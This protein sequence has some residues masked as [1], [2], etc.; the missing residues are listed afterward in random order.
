M[1][2]ARNRILGVSL[3]ARDGR[4]GKVKDFYVWRVRYIWRPL[5]ESKSGFD[6]TRGLGLSTLVRG[7]HFRKAHTGTGS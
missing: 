3:D 4:V 2:S 1:Y 5:A 7:S 6:F